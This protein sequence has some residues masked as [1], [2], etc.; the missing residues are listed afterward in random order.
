[1]AGKPEEGRQNTNP[2][3]HRRRVK[4]DARCARAHAGYAAIPLSP[5]TQLLRA[6][7]K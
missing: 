7:S 5:D 4:E 6:L 1:M 3:R 2:S